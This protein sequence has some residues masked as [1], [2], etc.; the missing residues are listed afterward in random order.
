MEAENMYM[1]IINVSSFPLFLLS[2][3]PF[4]LLHSMEPKA[5][6]PGRQWGIDKVK[7]NFCLLPISS[8][9]TAKALPAT[10]MHL[11]PS[12]KHPP[13]IPWSQGGGTDGGLGGRGTVET[14]VG[15]DCSCPSSLGFCLLSTPWKEGRKIPGVFDLS[16]P[17]CL[18][19][20]KHSL[21]LFPHKTCANLEDF[22]LLGEGRRTKPNLL[23][24]AC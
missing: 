12:K 11:T 5:W 24:A 21:P 9:P 4:F 6:E 14:V 13:C 19:F 2:L 7:A 1:Y 16:S 15:E 17:R 23:L 22:R 18:A 10:A 8:M 20:Q 3:V